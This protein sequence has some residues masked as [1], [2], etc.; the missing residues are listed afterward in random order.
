[1]RFNLFGDHKVRGATGH[2]S[3]A[4]PWL[5]LPCRAPKPDIFPLRVGIETNMAEEFGR[6]QTGRPCHPT[7][8]A[9]RARLDMRTP[10]AIYREV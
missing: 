1:M 10:C 7:E 8:A 6:V 3:R 9:L 2:V 5:P 4:E